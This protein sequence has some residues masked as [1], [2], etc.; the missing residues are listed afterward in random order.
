MMMMMM[1]MK[2]RENMLTGLSVFSSF[3]MHLGCNIHPSKARSSC[4]LIV[5]INSSGVK[6][7]AS[8]DDE[9][10]RS[11]RIWDSSSSIKRRNSRQHNSRIRSLT[12]NTPA[13][14][15]GLP[16]VLGYACGVGQIAIVGLAYTNPCTNV[17][18][19]VYTQYRNDFH[20][21]SKLRKK[22]TQ[23]TCYKNTT[24]LHV[25]VAAA[26]I[27]TILGQRICLINWRHAAGVP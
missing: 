1:M 22:P 11:L 25:S 8:L 24:K 21:D 27:C 18:V 3:I 23:W 5:F 15:I 26:V 19:L 9:F 4:L 6:R 7:R 10:H 20:N 14:H 13:N 16:L 17:Y 2:S 12:G